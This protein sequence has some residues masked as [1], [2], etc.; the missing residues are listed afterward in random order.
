MCIYRAKD[1]AP[2]NKLTAEAGSANPQQ[3]SCQTKLLQPS[4]TAAVFKKLMAA[5]KKLHLPNNLN[6]SIWLRL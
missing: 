6:I 3:I 2:E 5:Q 4:A 1:R